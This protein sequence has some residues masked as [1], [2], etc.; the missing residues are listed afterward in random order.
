MFRHSFTIPN[1]KLSSI[2]S[3]S[4]CAREGMSV[5]VVGRACGVAVGTFLLPAKYDRSDT[6]S[7]WPISFDLDQ[8]GGRRSHIF[9]A[10]DQETLFLVRYLNLSRKSLYRT[11]RTRFFYT[12]KRKSN[13]KTRKRKKNKKPFSTTSSASP[14]SDSAAPR[15][16]STA[17]TSLSLAA[18]FFFAERFWTKMCCP[19]P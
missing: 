16:Y 7:P 13:Q 6:T 2:D 12:K 17:P 19:H 15:F 9:E 11:Q 10:P 14:R 1:W 3:G 4:P 8:C 5:I 18:F